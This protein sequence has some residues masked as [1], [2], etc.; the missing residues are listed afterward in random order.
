MYLLGFLA[1]RSSHLHPLYSQDP[2]PSNIEK[3]LL[4]QRK[5]SLKVVYNANPLKIDTTISRKICLFHQ[6]I[7]KAFYK[8]ETS[9]F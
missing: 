8:G 2:S 6:K 4:L 1:F 3:A 5:I 7:S 9:P